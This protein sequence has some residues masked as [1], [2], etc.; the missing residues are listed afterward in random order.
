MRTSTRS[1]SYS[2]PQSSPRF[3]PASSNG[4]SI[5]RWRNSIAAQVAQLQREGWR[6]GL[7]GRAR[8][9]RG[10]PP[11]TPKTALDAV[12]RTSMRGIW[13]VWVDE[14][15][16]AMHLH[17]DSDLPPRSTKRPAALSRLGQLLVLCLLLLGLREVFSYSRPKP[18]GKIRVKGRDPFAILAELEPSPSIF[19]TSL[20][21]SNRLLKVDPVA[22]DGYVD[23]RGGDV[24]AVVLHWKRTENVGV[25]L[26][27][28]C[29]YSFIE[30]ITVWNNNPDIQLT[31]RCPAS[32]LRIYNSPRNLLFVA[33]YLACMQGSTPY[34]FFQDDDWVV[35]PL[36]SLYAQFKRDPEG[37][38]VVSTNSEVAALYGLEWC[39]YRQLVTL[40]CLTLF[41]PPAE[42]PLHTCFSWVGTGAFTSRSHVESFLD[43]TTSLAYPHEELAHADNSFSLFQNKPPYVLSH[44]L[45]QLPQPNG[46]SDG[47]GIARNKAYIVRFL[48]PYF[49]DWMVTVDWR[50]LQQK[51]LLHLTRFLFAQFPA[52]PPSTP[53]PKRPI[54]IEIS[55][56][57]HSL[58][59]PLPAH[60][61]AHHVRSPC[62]PSDACF[63][64]TNIPLLPPPDATPYPGPQRVRSLQE[65]EEHVG[66]VARGWVEGG[67]MWA[68]EERWALDWPYMNAV[69]GKPETAFR[70]ADSKSWAVEGYCELAREGDYIGLGLLVPLDAAW[71]PKVVLHVML[72]DID[73]FLPWLDVEISADGYH[74]LPPTHHRPE[75]ACSS[76]SYRSARPDVS[77]PNSALLSPHGAAARWADVAA[78]SSRFAAWWRRRSRRSERIKECVVELS[79]ALTNKGEGGWRFV[80]LVV[81]RDAEGAERQLQTGW[82][83]YEMWLTAP[84]STT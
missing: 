11:I 22:P 35:Q 13:A 39:F 52:L 84:T 1:P 8:L 21:G 2:S 57:R 75:F 56:Y 61:Y 42:H 70:S 63:F 36:R 51:G 68:E 33:R 30:S 14:K 54:A 80:R 67:E 29:Q 37:P 4:A 48:L 7:L 59:P 5:Q 72:E 81:K 26:A 19:T 62:M 25:I 15:P 43:T 77:F 23:M 31:S 83:V 49:A 71:A 34:C 3:P 6:K 12:I 18:R 20:P 41:V 65:W 79:S 74:W 78:T 9:S 45:T 47:E 16:S 53:L 27:S 66:W 64:L 32:K 24:T 46:H 73:K 69:D 44:K 28:L 50:D 40:C 82:G 60:P 58:S 17:A 38:I 55:P 10:G 76:T